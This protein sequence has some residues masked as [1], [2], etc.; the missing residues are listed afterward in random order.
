MSLLNFNTIKELFLPDKPS[1]EGN[2]DENSS[3]TPIITTNSKP[4]NEL[5]I[6][7]QDVA[8]LSEEEKAKRTSA[9]EKQQDD[10]N[11]AKRAN[12]T[13]TEPYTDESGRKFTLTTKYDKYGEPEIVTRT[14]ENGTIASINRYKDGILM[15]EETIDIT[16]RKKI[17]SFDSN[18][19]PVQEKEYYENGGLLSTT[20]WTYYSNGQLKEFN[21]T[22][23][24]QTVRKTFN[25]QGKPLV[26]KTHGK[27]GK[28]LYRDSF[29]EYKYNSKGEQ[30]YY[31]SKIDELDIEKIEG[32][33]NRPVVHTL[34]LNEEYINEYGIKVSH[35]KL[36][37]HSKDS[38][39][40]ECDEVG[41][42]CSTFFI[43]HDIK[44][45]SKVFVVLDENC[46]TRST[47]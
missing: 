44:F 38:R 34:R 2:S 32:L 39:V 35:S 47:T 31:S 24:A 11:K 14:R 21:S 41:R 19:N 18:E 40:E 30:I 42:S 36:S 1:L 33:K 12:K 27:I 43:E 3:S 46:P 26:I 6:E 13:I 29:T 25:E 17:T 22:G 45:S 9:R 8:P 23:G 20:D 28:F 15:E 4:I 10:I 37:K 16:G 5:E 7:H